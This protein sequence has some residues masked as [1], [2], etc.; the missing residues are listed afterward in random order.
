M[1][2]LT[3]LYKNLD[4]E[5][6]MVILEWTPASCS[7]LYQLQGFTLDEIMMSNLEVAE[8][9]ITIRRNNSRI[10]EISAA[11]LT[12]ISG[13]ALYF[14]LVAFG[15]L[16]VCSHQDTKTTFHRFDGMKSYGCHFR[17][18]TCQLL[19]RLVSCPDSTLDKKTCYIFLGLLTR[20]ATEILMDN[21][22]ECFPCMR[23]YHMKML[24]V[25]VQL[26]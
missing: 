1:N 5:Q 19:V 8:P 2:D 12:T 17:V 18:L 26:N 16:T 21:P 13:V 22:I 6:N 10:A 23:H 15:N 9:G 14:R 4:V 3:L 20:I 25:S 11:N 7:T 24:A